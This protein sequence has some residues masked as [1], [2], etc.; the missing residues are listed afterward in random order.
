MKERAPYS[1]GSFVEYNKVAICPYHQRTFSP[2]DSRVVRVVAKYWVV[3]NPCTIAYA[4]PEYI[5][6]YRHIS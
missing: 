3:S 6:L 4:I 2:F 1:S 5:L